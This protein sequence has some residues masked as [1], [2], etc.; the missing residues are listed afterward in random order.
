MRVFQCCICLD[1]LNKPS[2]LNTCKHVF[3]NNCIKGWHETFR[4]NKRPTCPYCRV[5]FSRNNLLQLKVT[6]QQLYDGDTREK[7]LDRNQWRDRCQAKLNDE[8]DRINMQKKIKQQE[9]SKLQE[10]LSTLTKS[11][12]KLNE[13][14]VEKQKK[15]ESLKSKAPL[16]SPLMDDIYQELKTKCGSLSRREPNDQVL[17]AWKNVMTEYNEYLLV[18][19][20]LISTEKKLADERTRYQK[21]K[22]K[23]GA[24]DRNEL[25]SWFGPNNYAKL[26]KIMNWPNLEPVTPPIAG[27]KRA[28]LSRRSDNVMQSRKRM[29]LFDDADDL[30]ICDSGIGSMMESTD[31]LD[32]APAQRKREQSPIASVPSHIQNRARKA[33]RSEAERNRFHLGNFFN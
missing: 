3:C 15:F 26:C 28:K 22:R 14:T 6:K 4:S 24:M 10:K 8:T 29:N 7:L 11:R 33:T 16:L 27:Q 17:S 20:Q 18:E 13:K 5:N 31:Y 1:P 21:D 25:A 12:D 2:I 9:M 30:D 23:Y 19:K 32:E